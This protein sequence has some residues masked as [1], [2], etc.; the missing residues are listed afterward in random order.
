MANTSSAK[1]AL[2]VSARRNAVNTRV[3]KAF[4]EV[5]KEIVKQLSTGN[6]KE[7]KKLLPKFQSE[8]DKAIKKRAIKKNTGARYKSR[9]VKMI[10]S[11]KK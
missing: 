6:Q 1:K 7:A 2:R 11:E 9:M 3:K 5:K 10:M 4:K 8:V